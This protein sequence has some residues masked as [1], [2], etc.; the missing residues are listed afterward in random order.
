M[1]PVFSQ[2]PDNAAL[3]AAIASKI[4]HEG[5]IRFHDFLRLDLYHPEHGYYFACDPTLDYQSSPNVHPV[6]GAMLARQVATFWRQLGRPEHFEIFEAG[7]GSLR[8]ATDLLHG[9]AQEE[10]ALFDTVRYTAQD[11]VPPA[12]AAYERLATA[13]IPTEK[14]RLA[15][16]LPDK[17][18]IT[19]C[20][21]S[22]EL[23]DALPFRRVRNQD[24]ALFEVLTGL[25]G[26]RFVDRLVAA[27]PE[28]RAYLDAIGCEPGEGC[29][30]EVNLE[31][32]S[33][34]RSAARALARGFVLTLDYGYEANELYAPQRRRGTLLT[35]YRHMS[36]DDPYRRIGLQDITASVDFTSV[37]RAGESAGLETDMFTTQ[38]DLLASLGIGSLISDTPP[39]NAL[40]AFY[41]LRRAIIELTDP[42][43]LGRIKALVQRKEVQSA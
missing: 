38:T 4:R 11:V 26:D 42:A 36:G 22:N 7:A 12:P 8:L 9:L 34:T 21:I 19:G 32:V 40:E 13:G 17:P 31:A 41:A 16:A 30:A 25:D 37:R 35:F 10:P 14:L 29:N 28:I 3:R 18:S 5:P 6:F 27:P 43:G 2:A 39:P 33:W 20:I 15:G 23:L 1:S 24:G